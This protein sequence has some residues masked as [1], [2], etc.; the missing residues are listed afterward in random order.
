MDRQTRN[1]KFA[2]II[3]NKEYKNKS[4]VDIIVM[5][6]EMIEKLKKELELKRTEPGFVYLGRN[7]KAMEYIESFEGQESLFCCQDLEVLYGI[8]RGDIDE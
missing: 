7:K 1:N 3:E 8:L 4:P 6:Y 5:Q 2:E